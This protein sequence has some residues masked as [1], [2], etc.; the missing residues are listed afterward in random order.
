MRRLCFGAIFLLWFIAA[1]GGQL[2][3]TPQLTAGVTEV[4]VQPSATVTGLATAAVSATATPTMRPTETPELVLPPTP[5]IEPTVEP[6]D[7]SLEDL[8]VV[9]VAPY[10]P[11]PVPT[12][13]PTAIVVVVESP[14]TAGA[15]AEIWTGIGTPMAAVQ[16]VISPENVG[17]LTLF[18]RWGKGEI[19]D[20]V[21]SA[22][23][24]QLA[25]ATA[26][27]VYIYDAASGEE[28]RLI[29]AR[30]EWLWHMA[31]SPDWQIVAMVMSHYEVELY[32]LSDGTFLSTLTSPEPINGLE[33]FTADGQTLLAG[34]AAWRVADGALLDVNYGI[35]A[36]AANGQ[37]VAGLGEWGSI[38]IGSLLVQG[39]EVVTVSSGI[40]V[41]D[42][43]QYGTVMAL[44]ADGQYLAVGGW[45]TNVELWRVADRTLLFD[46]ETRGGTS[47]QGQKEV[48]AS[49]ARH[50]G[51]GEYYVQNLAFS[52]DGRRLAVTTGFDQTTIWDTSN[53]NLVT[54]IV[55]ASGGVMFSPD[56]F[57]L[58]TWDASLTQWQASNGTP[59]NTLKQHM[60]S[61]GDVTFS[62]DGS[63]VIIGSDLIYMRRLSDGGL[64]SSL[65]AP[66]RRVEMTADGAT[67]ISAYR[68][69]LSIWNLV[70][71]TVINQEGSDSP[72][73]IGDL[74]LSADGQMVAT[75]A[76]D[77][78]VR[79]WRVSDGSLLRVVDE[80]QM[81]T[82]VVAFSPD[83]R[84][85]VTRPWE[86]GVGLWTVSHTTNGETRLSRDAEIVL[87]GPTG[88]TGDASSLAFSADGTMLV[89]GMREHSLQVWEVASGRL[90][91]QLD[92]DIGPVDG[93][94]FSPDGR[95]VASVSQ[96]SKLQLWDIQN[97][98]LLYT[99]VLPRYSL[100][101]VEF[102]PDG[103]YIVVGSSDGLVRLWGVP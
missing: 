8:V 93:V 21:Y 86:G 31:V 40:T 6:V 9:T 71:G 99:V 34:S 49:P 64:Y 22:D 27:G 30:T 18:G 76:H 52:P 55:G 70:D 12:A 91:Y 79:I 5:E 45:Y 17:Q 73:G 39:E 41:T 102:S 98:R 33:G 78:V 95:L 80:W 35:S 103:R 85:F 69:D 48:L 67:L 74:A 47:Q 29:P 72:W 68:G 88:E 10:T 63:Q 65:D 100:W 42:N 46:M 84:F 75:V 89:V 3:P 20:A 53:G 77:D 23:G 25:V 83:G 44:S 37:T 11:T 2:E 16:G 57:V 19:T 32:R 87:R 7:D 4:A 13:S 36:W 61:V 96:D 24:R 50:T 82:E 43:F 54:R 101:A 51:P 58:A 66:A 59:I 56:S 15:T 97:P 14:V 1:C 38:D 81:G 60:G 90:V 62:P 94:A 28:I 26:L 92:G